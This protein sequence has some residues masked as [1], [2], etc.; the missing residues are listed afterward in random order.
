MLR[1]VSS[2][3][4]TTIVIN[5]LDTSTTTT[6]TTTAWTLTSMTALKKTIAGI[7][8]DSDSDDDII[9]IDDPFTDAYK[10]EIHSYIYSPKSSKIIAETDISGIC[11]VVRNV[12]YLVELGLAY[13]GELKDQS[14]EQKIKRTIVYILSRIRIRRANLGFLNSNILG[15]ALD[16]SNARELLAQR[17]SGRFAKH[18]M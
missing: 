7:G 11:L 8:D 16:D 2:P 6:T 15:L 12:K 13:L 3:G 18:N 17:V 4:Y 9:G 14:S 1:D 10:A 5:G